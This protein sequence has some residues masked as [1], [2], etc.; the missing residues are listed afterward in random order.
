[1][2]KTDNGTRK[3][4]CQLKVIIAAMDGKRNTV[5]GLWVKMVGNKQ[6]KFGVF[7][8]GVRVGFGEIREVTRDD[9]V[10]EGW[11]QF[12]EGNDARFDIGD[13]TFGDSNVHNQAMLDLGQEVHHY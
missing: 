13:T 12:V 11:V 10:S 6:L 9:G 4:L 1:M 3:C 7:L 8:F 2:K 5:G